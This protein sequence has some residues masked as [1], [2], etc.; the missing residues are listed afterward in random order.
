MLKKVKA[1]AFMIFQCFTEKLETYT[2]TALHYTNRHL[3]EKD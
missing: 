2:D 3:N 1:L